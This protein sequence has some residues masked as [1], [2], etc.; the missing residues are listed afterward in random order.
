[1]TLQLRPTFSES[2]Y[3]V[4]NLKAKLR[5]GAQISRQFYRGERW[6]VVRDPAGNQYHRLSDA[7][8]RFVGLLDGSRTVEQA[9][10]LVGGTLE[11]DAPT[12]PE[13]IQI[14]SHLYSAN[15]VDADVTP[16]ATVLLRRHKN[17]SKRKMQNRLMNV[18]FPRI[19]LWDPDRFLKLWMPIARV[20]FSKF[21]ALIWIAM[22]TAAVV[23]LVPEWGSGGGDHNLIHAAEKSVNLHSNPINALYLWFVF[24]FIKL[25]HEL[26]HA[27]SCRRFGGEC[28]EL[29]IMFLV[30]IP[31]P[32]VDASSAWSF[33]NKWHRIFVGAAG[34]IVELFFAAICAFIWKYTPTTE[35][36]NQLA[37]NAMLVAS[38]T[39]LV[40]NANP[41]LRYDGYYILSDFLEIPNLRQ[42]SSDY[43]MGLIKR[44]I[45]GV[46]LQQPLPPPLQRV[47][48]LLYSI[49]S[50]I[51]R[52]FV[53]VVIILLVAFQIPILGLLMAIGGLV[54]WLAVP[55]FKVFKYLTL[56]PELHRK[57]TRA[58]IF[59]VAVTAAVVVLIGFVPFP[60]NV[61]EVGVAEA[62]A[63]E[64]VRPEWGGFVTDIVAKDHQ[65]LHGPIRDARGKI[66]TPGDVILVAHDPDLDKDIDSTSFRVKYYQD[67][68]RADRPNDANLAA[69]DQD[70]LDAEQSKLDELVG[71]RDKLTLRA[72][73]SGELV[74]PQL[75]DM[76]GKYLKQG[77]DIG[78][79][80]QADNFVIRVLLEQ[81][82][83]G[84]IVRKD[85]KNP[86]GLAEN[87]D[88]WIRLASDVGTPL[89]G[90][91]PQLNPYATDKSPGAAVTN[92]SGEEAA[93]NPQHP[94]KLMTD[95]F[96]IDVPMQNP[97]MKYV[98][99][100]KA[101][102][103]F[104][105]GK[106]PLSWQWW[107]KILQLIQTKQ[108]S[109]LV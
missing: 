3:R 10:E 19:P 44:H 105:L 22:L 95:E 71:R 51:Y 102:V 96:E 93:V 5:A 104:K 89:K 17:L 52:T 53:G 42:K 68:M 39:T 2:W 58:T 75:K 14:L 78:S 79:V 60:M 27:F 81:K 8:Y 30:F 85:S 62:Q 69:I 11:D 90:G 4:A 45:F 47:W 57:R 100:Q 23:A 15:L 20:L 28:H 33:R 74:S 6:Y 48:L 107:R 9:W 50:S 46:K 40:F 103:R 56:D 26:G 72:P 97:G 82:E 73:I 61:D 101:W 13:V 65:Y 49:T 7:A 18:L 55:V 64:S 70:Q 88:A 98:P 41:L 25:I 35:V 87:V 34:M 21:G 43:S 94:E 12:Q 31:T 66:I 54:T 38:F 77:D 108:A 76:G 106:Q 92:Q 63:H 109:P 37:F 99:G 91:A 86:S 80:I 24:C 32:Y 36:I 67:K 84:V 16:D 1:M 29:G 83:S 59:T